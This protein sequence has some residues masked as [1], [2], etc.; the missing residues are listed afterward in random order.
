[1]NNVGKVLQVI[2]IAI[3]L[4]VAD[5]LLNTNRFLKAIEIGQECLL[6][7]ED[8]AGLID[9][10]ISSLCYKLIYVT[11]WK[12]CHIINDITNA[13]KCAEKILQIDRESGERLEEC[14]LSIKLAEMYLHQSKYAKAKQTSKKAL[15]ISREVNHKR[16]EATSFANLGEVYLSVGK[17]DKAREHLEKS[18]AIRK[19][20]GHRNG[21]AACY[22]NLGN[23]YQSFGEYEKAKE[24][25]PQ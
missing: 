11:M 2:S 18:L 10:K 24:E 23:V 13:I 3:G 5:F 12:A 8:T 6:I 20:T 7:L 22:G 17:Y 1:M 14:E 16:G 25:G 19:E 15:Q 9:K 21:E 4:L